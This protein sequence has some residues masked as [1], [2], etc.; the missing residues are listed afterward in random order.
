MTSAINLERFV[1]EGQHEHPQATGELLHTVKPARGLTGVPVRST[2]TGEGG[3]PY[4][5]GLS[6]GYQH[7]LQALHGSHVLGALEGS[8]IGAA[9]LAHAALHLLHRFIFVIFHPLPHA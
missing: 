3:C 9:E 2:W 6:A 1:L 4:T 5:I 7:V 8:W